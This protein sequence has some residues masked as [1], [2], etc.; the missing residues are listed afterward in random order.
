M[1]TLAPDGNMMHNFKRITRFRQQGP[2]LKKLST[3]LLFYSVLLFVLV[4]TSLV[5]ADSRNF[6]AK[7]GFNRSAQQQCS[8]SRFT[9][10][11]RAGSMASV[12][13]PTSPL[14]LSYYCRIGL[15][16]GMAGAAG[17][18]I[19]YPL[20]VAK[21]LR[22]TSPGKYRSVSDAL[23]QLVR[24]QAPGE[25][26]KWHLHKAYR[27]L[28]PAVFGAISSSA[29]YFGAYESSKRALETKLGTATA[30]RRLLV[31]GLAAASGN[32]LSSALFVPKEVLKQQ[33]QH[34]SLS[35]SHSLS[36]VLFDIIRTK[37]ISGLYVGYQATLMRN[38]P[39]AMLRFIL[40]EEFK[41]IWGHRNGEQVPVGLF[42][43]G[44]IAG[45]IASGIMTPIDVVKTRLATGM[46]PPGVGNCL[47]H[48]VQEAG[49]SGLYAGAGTRIL[50]SAAFSA[51]GFGTFELA[52]GVMGVAKV[53]EEANVI[54]DQKLSPISSKSHSIRKLSVSV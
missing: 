5:G 37:G 33:M 49:W 3:T 23:F 29:L 6:F 11:L 1:V 12:P 54:L 30:A 52:K 32:S 9:S 50:W 45:A 13:A 14:G 25:S 46:C 36:G 4:H 10:K 21:T 39:S 17:T 2:C 47:Q 8:T 20:D 7:G 27:G 31:H 24:S 42:A 40:Y 35:A 38:I 44:A 41:R 34:S 51:I 16:G 28:I 22:Q 15:A 18:S 26:V 48:V 19:L 43:S 53:S